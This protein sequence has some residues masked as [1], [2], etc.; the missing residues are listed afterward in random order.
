MWNSQIQKD[1]LVM[2]NQS[3]MA[4]D[5]QPKRAAATDIATLSYSDIRKKKHEKL[6][7]YRELN[8]EVEKMVKVVTG[9]LQ[10]LFTGIKHKEMC[11]STK[12]PQLA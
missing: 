11:H 7:K 12:C 6:E 5:K 8:E 9:T 2:A 4:L 10:L 3:D 1:K